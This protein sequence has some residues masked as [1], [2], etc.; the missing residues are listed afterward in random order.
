MPCYAFWIFCE[1]STFDKLT[2]LMELF[3]V[4][5]HPQQEIYISKL[6][7][8]LPTCSAQL[9]LDIWLAIGTVHQQVIGRLKG[10]LNE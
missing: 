5:L 3:F 1:L 7:M 6:C 4:V 2:R 8:S 9:G 10:P